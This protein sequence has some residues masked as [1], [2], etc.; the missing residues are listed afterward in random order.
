VTDESD[1][2]KR[3]YEDLGGW[4]A[5]KSG[6]WV[7]RLIQKC[8]KNYWERATAEYFQEKY[9]TTDPAK[10]TR[11]LISVAAKNAS[12]LG[13]ATGATVSADEMVAIVTAGEGGVGLPANIA[14]AMV[15]LSTEQILFVRIQLKL[16]AQ[17][18]KVYGVPLDPDDPE[19]ILTILAFALGGTA[20]HA[21]GEAGMKIGGRIAGR[22]AKKLFSKDLLAILKRVAAKV[23]VRLLQR[24][25]FHGPCEA[26]LHDAQADA[27]S[28]KVGAA[29]D[30]ICITGFIGWRRLLNVTASRRRLP[31][32]SDERPL[33]PPRRRMR[34]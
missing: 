29:L 6:E 22:A 30:V 16:L 23:G 28:D 11:K 9:H 7:F 20:A 15:A 18:G 8:F 10:L 21:A 5:F 25:R 4:E 1:D 2:A 12:L 3:D 32:R 26:L 14:I 34:E 31:Y 33:Q 24:R 13:A 17:L 27:E 19:D